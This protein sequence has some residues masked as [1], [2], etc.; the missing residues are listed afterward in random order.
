MPECS[1]VILAAGSSSRLGQPKQLLSYRGRPLLRHA[2]EEA[3]AAGIGP[4]YVVTGAF[5]ELVRPS[6][7]GLPV[8]LVGNPD[9]VQGMSS[10]IRAGVTAV[11]QRDSA[12]LILALGDQPK[13]EARHYR[14]L[15]R[16]QQESGQSIVASRYGASVGVPAL[17]T[18]KGF[19][20]LLA[21]EGAQ[22]CKGVI[23]GHSEEASFL[24]CPEAEIDVDTPEDYRQLVGRDIQN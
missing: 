13:I 15:L 10:S 24:D 8:S 5:E 2:A 17:F 19:P 23:I 11:Q 14:A 22:G 6:L 20:W 21:L 4:V 16:R 12:G 18:P 3:L 1:I 9:W 7:D